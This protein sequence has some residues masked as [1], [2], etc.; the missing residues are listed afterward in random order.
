MS[1]DDQLWQIICIF[2]TFLFGMNLLFIVHNIYK[3]I[4][5]LRM[6]QTLILTFYSLL[7]LSTVTRIAEFCSRGFHPEHGFYPQEDTFITYIN[8]FA[9]TFMICVELTL[10]LTMLRL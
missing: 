1:F 8:A 5:G 6:K 10:I 2:Y 4:Y 9:L 7:L 3:Y